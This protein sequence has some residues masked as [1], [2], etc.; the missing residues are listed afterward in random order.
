MQLRFRNQE[1]QQ[2]IEESGYVT[3]PFLNH[4][5][6]E[7][8]FALYQESAQDA[9]G[10]HC[11]MFNPDKDYRRSVDAQIKGSIS[12]KLTELI[13]GANMLY[14]NFLVKEPGEESNFFVHQDWTYVDESKSS[15]WAIWIPLIDT[16]LSNGALHLVPSSHRMKNHFRGPGIADALDGL[17]DIIRS[18]HGIA[19]NLKAG[20]AVIWDHRV[21][22]YSPANLSKDRRVAATV[23]LTP[24]GEKVIHCR[25]T[26]NPLEVDIFDVNTEF[27]MNYEIDGIPA[28]KPVKRFII[29]SPVVTQSEFKQLIG[30]SDKSEG[31]FSKVKSLFN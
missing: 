28:S 3:I 8:L 15:S 30:I 1:L 20:E 7:N 21:V 2:R 27:Y 18:E 24:R 19:V 6:V 14:A 29:D 31:I 4:E 11:T 16:D 13:E 12:D 9:S 26:S 17:H 22:H 5:Q 10:F 23:I 25:A